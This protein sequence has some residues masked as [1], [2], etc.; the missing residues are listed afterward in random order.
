MLTDEKTEG[1]T[2]EMLFSLSQVWQVARMGF[3]L[4]SISLGALASRLSGLRSPV[5]S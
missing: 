2:V 5:L 4:A 1:P 3:E